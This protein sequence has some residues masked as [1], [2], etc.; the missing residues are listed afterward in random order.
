MEGGHCLA[1]AYLGTTVLVLQIFNSSWM[2]WCNV[3][4]LAQLY[5][6]LKCLCRERL[7]INLT[8][9]AKQVYFYSLTHTGSNLPSNV[10]HRLWIA[11]SNASSLIKVIRNFLDSSSPNLSI[12]PIFI[13][14]LYCIR[15]KP[16]SWKKLFSFLRIP[17]PYQRSSFQPTLP[18][19]SSRPERPTS[20][21]IK[22]VDHHQL[23]IICKLLIPKS[24]LTAPLPKTCL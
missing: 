17:N 1:F 24:T 21:L 16:S 11:K 13:F 19:G 4:T 7:V 2:H 14:S 23:F 5:C 10:K 6:K 8:W 12:K 3:L 20:L 22:S 18:I 15:L 9:N